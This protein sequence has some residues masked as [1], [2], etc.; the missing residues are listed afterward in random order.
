MDVHRHITTRIIMIIKKIELPQQEGCQHINIELENGD[1]KSYHIE[2]FM[3]EEN[4]QPQDEVFL[5]LK[6]LYK[7]QNMKS[8]EDI[9]NNLTNIS[10]E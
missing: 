3:A 10:L 4:T 7:A 5:Q 9:K 1:K 2:D 6:T 8:R